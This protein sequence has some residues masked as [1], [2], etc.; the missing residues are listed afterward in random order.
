LDAFFKLCSFSR[1]RAFSGPP[2]ASS[3]PSPSSRLCLKSRTFYSLLGP[4]GHT[5]SLSFG[6]RLAYCFFCPYPAGHKGSGCK[7]VRPLFCPSF[8]KLPPAPLF[9][10]FF[11]FFTLFDPGRALLHPFLTKTSLGH[12]PSP[13]P[14]Y[15]LAFH[16][17]IKF[18]QVTGHHTRLPS[19][20]SPGLLLVLVPFPETLTPIF[21]LH[22]KD[23]VTTAFL[24]PLPCILDYPSPSRFQTRASCVL[25]S[26]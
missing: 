1:F 15:P 3:R 5:L 22:P 6:H 8:L 9:A 7:V 20:L 17:N 21:F 26:L 18:L 23:T 10:Q 24:P 25:G 14:H 2:R 19:P 12:R 13:H 11:F 16:F 4:L